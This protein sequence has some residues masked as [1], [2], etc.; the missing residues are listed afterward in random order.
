M[1]TAIERVMTTYGM[2]V[3][4]TPEQQQ[5]ARERVGR[6]LQGKGTDEHMLAVEGLKYLRRRATKRRRVAAKSV[7]HRV[8]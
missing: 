8:E 2:M 7:Q 4:L 3:D 1:Q 6:F 5:E